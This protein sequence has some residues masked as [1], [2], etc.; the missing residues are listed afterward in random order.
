LLGTSFRRTGLAA[1][2]ALLLALAAPAAHAASPVVAAAGDIACDPADPAYNGGDGT[3]TA[4]RMK[5]TSDLLLGGGWSAVL[6]LGDNQY[7]DGALARYQASYDPTWG[8]VKGLTFP[9]PGNHEYGTAGAAGYFAYFGAAAGDPARGYYSFDLGAWHFVV[10][11]S[12]CAA[13]G[14][15]GPGSAQEQWLA[16]DLAAHPGRC[17]LAYWHHP[18]FSSGQHG[19]DPTTQ[20][21][22]SDLYGAGADVV[23]S[24][25]DHIYER[26]APQ[27]P[28]G[29]ADPGRGLRQFVVGTG[30]RNQ[31]PFATVR[32]NSAARSSG[33]FGVLALTLYPNGYDWRFV[34]A[35][36]G[37]SFADAGTG[38]CHSALPAGLMAFHTLPPCRLL[39][40]RGADG[41]ALA[42]NT[43]NTAAARL[44]PAAGRCGVPETAK[45]IAANVTVIAPGNGGDLR[46]FP[47][48]AA[49]P[50]ASTVSVVRGRT[51]T[52]NAVLALGAGGRIAAQYDLPPGSAGTAHLVVDLAG[53][54]E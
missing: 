44:F 9:A 32:P 4:C 3:A 41:P 7:E 40:T 49:V 5:A 12:N 2:L 11:N 25:H 34:P 6:L 42:G 29:N 24:G 48:G 23:L 51:R 50:L 45:A 30:G 18:R 15:C 35:A 52:N 37:G 33:V 39:D 28:A 31:T 53:Y 21:F 54:F 27:D 10:L 47:A 43:G 22:W 36:G 16:A 1:V 13:V 46:L 19:D 14:G 17:T 26:F 38:L 8:R 20:T